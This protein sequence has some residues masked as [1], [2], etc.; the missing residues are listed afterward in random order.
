MWRSGH[1]CTEQSIFY[2]TLK[3][4][5]THTEKKLK[6]KFQNRKN[7]QN[8]TKQKNR[9]NNI[10][11]LHTPIQRNNNNNLLSYTT[12]S[13]LHFNINTLANKFLIKFLYSLYVISL[14]LVILLLIKIYLNV[15]VNILVMKFIHQIQILSYQKSSQVE[16]IS[17]CGH[18]RFH[19]YFKKLSSFFDY[20]HK[21]PYVFLYQKV[22]LLEC[23]LIQLLKKLSNCRCNGFLIMELPRN[24]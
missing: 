9:K 15:C 4:E 7:L 20:F 18:T 10:I 21:F 3:L 22:F 2:D 12:F 5:N 16:D 11:I 17:C 24:T 23:T 19:N 8:K 1:H 13:Q 6:N 14:V